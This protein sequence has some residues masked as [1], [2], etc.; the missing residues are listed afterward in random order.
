MSITL[1]QTPSGLKK[2]ELPSSF[3]LLSYSTLGTQPVNKHPLQGF[4]MALLLKFAL[5]C[6]YP[7]LISF[8]NGSSASF[9][10]PP[11]HSSLLA[12]GSRGGTLL[13]SSLAAAW[14][15][16]SPPLGLIWKTWEFL[17]EKPPLWS[18]W[19]DP[20]A[21]L[22][23]CWTSDPSFPNSLALGLVFTRVTRL[24]WSCYLFLKV[25]K[26]GTTLHYSDPWGR[27]GQL[28]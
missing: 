17:Q 8:S 21:Q 20:R 23:V 12:V 14:Q 28:F 7:V 15:S 3:F 27:P 9:W 5:S 24:G 25:E 16:Y 19:Q 4:Q 2:F 13:P 22:W 18:Q 26:G 6:T 10:N 11:V 1:S